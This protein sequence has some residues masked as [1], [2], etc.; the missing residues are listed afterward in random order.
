MSCVVHHPNLPIIDPKFYLWCQNLDRRS[1][2]LFQPLEDGLPIIRHGDLEGIKRM[3]K[4]AVQRPCD[5][6]V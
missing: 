1:L 5:I 6:L 4:D 2:V 3:P